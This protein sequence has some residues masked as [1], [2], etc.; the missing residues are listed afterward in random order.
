MVINHLLTGMILQVLPSGKLT[1]LAGKWT[2]IED[3]FSLEA[4][5]GR[6]TDI[7]ASW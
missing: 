4:T 6:K 2:R 3:V 1:W 7:Q 5:N